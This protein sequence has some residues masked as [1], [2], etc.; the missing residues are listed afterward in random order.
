MRDASALRRPWIAATLIA[1]LSATALTTFGTSA[2]KANFDEPYSNVTLTILHNNDGE[3][4]L[5]PEQSYRTTSGT[6]IAGG[7]AAFASVMKREVKNARRLNQ[8]VLSV[9]AGDSFLASKALICA[10]PAKVD[11]TKLV[12]D[13]V[14]QSLMPYDVHALGNHE[15]DYGTTFLR[16]YMDSFVNKPRHP[17]ISGNLDFTANDDLSDIQAKQPALRRGNFIG[18]QVASSYIHRDYNTGAFFGVV[19][20]ITPNLRTISSPGTVK[21]TS[22]DIKST[23]AEVQKQV[24][25]LQEQ[26]LNKIILVSHLQGIAFDRELISLLKDVDVAIAGGGDDLLANPDVS[27]SLQLIPGEGKPVGKYPEMVKDA[28][29]VDVPL[30][31][32]KGNYTYLGRFDVEFSADG[33]VTGYNKTLS[34]PRRV[35]ATSTVSRDL[36]ITDAVRPDAR[37]V[38]EAETPLRECLAGFNTPIA[39]SK[40]VFATDRGSATVAGVRTVETNGGNLVADSFVHAYRN[41]AATFGLPAESSAAPVVALQNGGGIRQNGGVTLPT[42]GSAGNINRGN[43]FDLLP[44]DN[45]LVAITSVSAAD[46]KEIFERSCAV[47]T[48]G[49]GQFLQVSGL[50]V[51]CSRS[52]TAMVVSNPVGDSYA[53]SVTTPGTRVRDITL[54]DGR[55]LVTAGSVV[56]G[57]PSVTVVT[58][59]FTAEGGDNYPTLAKLTKVGFGIS[60]EQALYD[61]VT[62]F[63]KNSGGLPEIPE[64]DLRYSKVT[65]EGRITWLP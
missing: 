43:T 61:Y 50:K 62:S 38:T 9:Y 22:S 31:T 37:V 44:F 48:S 14:A 6:L 18:K 10:D 30:I 35:I 19:S 4:A 60:Y 56:T 55:A 29:G 54:A 42:S 12:L 26:G 24:D 3:S 2:A 39:S 65:G 28:G 53:G 33:E 8:A 5:L 49:G 52:G 11:S 58:N 20:A 63:P 7:A 46:I 34:Y 59:S 47:G 32:T 17:F 57:A 27:E 15:F 36:K 40:V 45:R 41:R 51:S 23:A 13:G 16:R 25:A 21:L 1:A 64:S